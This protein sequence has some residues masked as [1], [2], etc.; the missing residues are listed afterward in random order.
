MA[1]VKR[2]VTAHSKHKK[3]LKK[4]KGYYGAR[5]KQIREQLKID[6]DT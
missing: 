3:V 4:A 6:E 5:R 1:R 2:G